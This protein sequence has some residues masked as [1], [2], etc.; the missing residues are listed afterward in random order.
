MKITREPL[1][2]NLERFEVTLARSDWY[3]E[4]DKQLRQARREMAVQGFRKG[5]A[6]LGL[7]AKRMGGEEWMLQ[8]V[9]EAQ[10]RGVESYVK[11]QGLSVAFPF[12]P[13]DEEIAMPDLKAE[14]T[15]TWRYDVVVAPKYELPKK[16]PWLP[17]EVEATDEQWAECEK[18]ILEN[19]NVTWKSADEVDDAVVIDVNFL[20]APALESG[21]E[22]KESDTKFY[23]NYDG[24]TE[25]AKTLLKGRKKDEEVEF[26]AGF[27]PYPKGE[28]ESASG[29]YDAYE[30]R[31]QQM[32]LHGASVRVK[33]TNVEKRVAGEMSWEF[34][35]RYFA[36]ALQAQ[37][38][39]KPMEEKTEDVDEIRKRFRT[40]Y[41]ELVSKYTQL[42]N[43][44][45]AFNEAVS[46]W[47]WSVSEEHLKK[48]L[49]QERLTV[50][51]TEY[52]MESIRQESLRHQLLTSLGE[53]N[54]QSE[55][56]SGLGELVYDS[57]C[58]DALSRA[59]MAGAYGILPGAM[60]MARF[61]IHSML[62]QQ[63]ESEKFK[64]GLQDSFLQA[65]A[66][67][68]LLSQ[69]QLKPRKVGVNRLSVLGEVRDEVEAQSRKSAEKWKRWREEAEAE[70]AKRE[71][72]EQQQAEGKE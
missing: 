40:R 18:V 21:E 23:F 55:E 19:N 66:G 59:G 53:E 32:G 57:Q 9:S 71:A 38:E 7:V 35:E 28:K 64:K 61:F 70:I 1:G 24:M 33:I 12:V 15:V 25:E 27:N 72:E 3:E 42:S 29:L 34:Y 68:Y 16:F 65:A 67:H 22:R 14:E 50:I 5:Q 51:P 47:S 62:P 8:F 56:Y 41:V 20:N 36:L 6:P 44:L 58:M 52:E 54:L 63:A 4:Y 48:M 49:E 17:V 43:A 60:P 11:E 13:S 30:N 39:N 46:H 2:E 45:A 10:N 26:E 31:L 37:A 69:L